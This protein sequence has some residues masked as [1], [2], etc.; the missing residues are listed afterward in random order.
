MDST[1]VDFVKA[2]RTAE[3]KVS[4]AETLD[5]MECLDLVGITDRNFLKDSLALV[6]SKTPEEKEAFDACF[7]RF[8]A[9]ESFSKSDQ[10]ANIR[11]TSTREMKLRENRLRERAHKGA[12]EKVKAVALAGKKLQN[13]IATNLSIHHW[14]QNPHWVNCCFQAQEQNLLFPWLKRDVLPK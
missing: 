7:D 11:M 3:I 10:T 6:L 5:A 2:L 4:P 12:P 8:F 9:F 14:I 13:Q 1:L